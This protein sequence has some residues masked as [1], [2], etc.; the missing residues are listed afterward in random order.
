MS[1]L[2]VPYSRALEERHKAAG[3]RY[4]A[5]PVFGRPEAAASRALRIVVAGRPG[6]WRRRGLFF[7]PWA[8]RSTWW[9]SVPT[10]PTR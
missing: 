5:A 3:R 10:R 2:G 9:G 7:R 4:L 6:T 8:R 1:T